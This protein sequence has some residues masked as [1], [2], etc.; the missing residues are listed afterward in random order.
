MNNNNEP[1]QL[2]QY[3]SIQMAIDV[4][5][6][7]NLKEQYYNENIELRAKILNLSKNEEILQETIKGNE[8]TI[9]ALR[10]ENEELKNR[11]N[12]IEEKLNIAL[13]TIKEQDKTIKEQDSKINNLLVDKQYKKFMIAIQ[14]MNRLISLEQ[15]NYNNN[16]INKNLAKLR[17]DRNDEY[18]YILE[19]YEDDNIINDKRIILIEQITKY[20]TKEVENKFNKRYPNVLKN[21]IQ[22][23]KPENNV[24]SSNENE[25]EI[26][27]WWE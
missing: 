24:I 3:G 1:K 17:N 22:Y 16:I 2:Q 12:E 19:D 20:M 6:L 4:A 9:E 25:E 23:I 8:Q 27:E 13:K 10:K 21:I 26:R 11:L 14:D 18:H 5:Q 15:K 7:Y